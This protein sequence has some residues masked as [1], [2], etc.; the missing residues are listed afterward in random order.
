M[1]QQIPK[2]KELLYETQLLG[3]VTPDNGTAAS[4]AVSNIL[5]R[6]FPV[7]R[8]KINDHHLTTIM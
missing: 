3:I 2:V 5:K 6:Q 7:N 8:I 4:Q 1:V